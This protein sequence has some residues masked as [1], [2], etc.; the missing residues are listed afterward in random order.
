[1]LVMFFYFQ[2]AEA[3]MQQVIGVNA[4]T[5]VYATPQLKPIPGVTYEAKINNRSGFE[6]GL[7][8]RWRYNINLFLPPTSEIISITRT[9]LSGYFAYRY[10]A[11][12]LVITGGPKLSTLLSWRQNNTGTK[13][14][15]YKENPALKIGWF[16]RFSKVFDMDNNLSVEPDI[17]FTNFNGIF[18]SRSA[19]F[20]V[21]V[22]LKYKLLPR[23]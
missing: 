18:S 5:E 12:W 10:Y 20:L 15:N 17:R 9:Y 1:M 22:G 8:Y 6:A 21:G 13:I 14:E 4:S 3:Q 19:H 16:V 11:K 23:P 2:E 7:I